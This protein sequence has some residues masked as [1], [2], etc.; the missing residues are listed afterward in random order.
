MN[1][2]IINNLK[3]IFNFKNVEVVERLLGGMSNYTFV[4]RCDGDFYT[5]RIPGE[6][7]D[8]FVDRKIEIKNIEIVESLGI[9]NKTVYL[10]VDNGIKL[11]KYIPGKPLSTI[12]EE[13]YPYEE[14]SKILK[15]IHNSNLKAVND[16]DPFLRLAY[17]EKMV[18]E[19]GYVHNE[20]YLLQKT[21]FFKYKSFLEN[22]P[23]VLTHGDSQPSNFVLG[24]DSLFVVDFEFC[25]NNDPIYDIACFA[26]KNYEEGNKL[27]YVYYDT[28]TKEQIDRFNLWRAFQ[29]FQW[30]NVA[31]FKEMTGLSE[32]LHIDFKKV[33]EKYLN[34]II[35]LLEKVE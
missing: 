13:Q 12:S 5:Y 10:N 34:L 32:K 29:C 25:G 18:K 27:L 9:T 30:Y 14:V 17:Y 16:Y 4:V 24:E 21:K 11:A 6:F 8:H 2:R 35:S 20:Q 31:V 7:S 23:K 22:T 28:P 26:N 1:E 19:L 3:Q 33:A 15:V